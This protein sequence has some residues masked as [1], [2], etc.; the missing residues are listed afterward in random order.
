[1][2]GNEETRGNHLFDDTLPASDNDL[3][4]KEPDSCE[5]QTEG[6]VYGVNIQHEV[7]L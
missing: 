6:G 1:M 7:G 3:A 5:G 2:P 4:D